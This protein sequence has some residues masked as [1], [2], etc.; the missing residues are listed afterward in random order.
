MAK[1]RGLTQKQEIFCVT[2]VRT[3]SATEAAR[4]AGYSQRRPA[5]AG[6]DNLKNPAVAARVEELR[7]RT[8]DETI[9]GIMERKRRLSEIVRGRISDY[10]DDQGTRFVVDKGKSNPGAVEHV[11]LQTQPGSNG[12]ATGIIS[13]KLYDPIR[14]IAELNRM[15]KVYREGTESNHSGVITEIVMVR[16]EIDAPDQPRRLNGGTGVTD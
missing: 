3:G 8:E 2:Y 16:P 6:W 12:E 7:R 5:Q 4:A 14:A 13:L 15:E 11:N 9:A 1:N 10:L